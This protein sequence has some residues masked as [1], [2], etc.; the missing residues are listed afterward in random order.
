TIVF[1]YKIDTEKSQLFLEQGILDIKLLL[2]Y[3]IR[4]SLAYEKLLNTF[5]NPSSTYHQ[6]QQENARKQQEEKEHQDYFGETGHEPTFTRKDP[7]L[8]HVD[9]N[10]KNIKSGQIKSE[11]KN[12]KDSELGKLGISTINMSDSLNDGEC[13]KE[14]TKRNLG[15]PQGHHT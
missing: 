1:P 15:V 8:I 13:T 14:P 6:R 3:Y 11:S 5:H 10:F 2:L 7:D 4:M 9:E 12:E